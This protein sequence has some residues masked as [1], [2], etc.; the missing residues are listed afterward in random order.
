SGN[1]ATI[2]GL[3]PNTSYQFRV[4]AKDAAGNQSALSD[5]V[6]ATT[7]GTGG[8]QCTAAVQ[9]FPYNQGFENSFGSWKQSNNDNIDWSTRTGQTPSNGTG[10]SSAH[11]GSYY[12]YVE[13]SVTGTGHPNKRA[14]LTS[15]CFDL[16]NLTQA[17]VSFNYHMY[18]DN[19]MGSIAL[20]ASKDNGANWVSLWS[21]T[22]N[23]GNN[24]LSASIDL[25]A[26]SGGTVQLRFNRLTG[27][28]WKA[29]IAI[30]NFALKSAGTTGDICDGI[31]E[32]RSGQ[33]YQVG[34]KVTYR[35][36]LFERIATGSGWKRLGA[37]GTTFTRDQKTASLNVEYPPVINKLVIEPNPIKGNILHT[38]F[39]P[40][41]DATYSIIDI[42]GK[43][44]REGDFSTDINVTGIPKGVYILKVLSDKKEHTQRFIK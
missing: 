5:A 10:P 14:I 32:W 22:G 24:W 16:T 42:Q 18:G 9:T 11:Q 12:I 2:T 29:D 13:A 19:D 25:S 7:S 23:K 8:D 17:T 30:D 31:E 20:E 40:S 36:Y 38:L 41:K 4:R 26:Y 3:T 34:D 21:Q 35:G 37:C 15:P 43:I 27:A 39:I 28:T 33:T 1:S 6:S 44:I